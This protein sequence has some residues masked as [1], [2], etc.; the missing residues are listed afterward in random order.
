MT[1]LKK[2]KT[3]LP[4][5][6]AVALTAL[7]IV[8]FSYAHW[9]DTLWL[10]GTVT[11]GTLCAEFIDVSNVKDHGP[12]WTCDYG[13]T[14]I[15]LLDPP[16]DIGSTTAWIVEDGKCPDTI[17]VVMDNVYPC[18][19]EE[20]SFHI[21]NCGTI[22]WVI[23]KVTFKPGNIVITKPDYLTL[24]L[25]G[26]GKADIELKWGDNFGVQIDPGTEIE[27]SFK[28]HVLQDAPQDTPMSFTAEIEMINWN[29]YPLPP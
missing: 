6:V 16:K 10:K 12:D 3:S 11:T 9:S 18:Y 23:T 13:I 29:E 17:M 8:G 22:P 15:R 24:D 14:D 2:S 5:I 21:R 4:A 20:I 1:L 27:V 28:I 26:D 19:Y 7:T 25:T